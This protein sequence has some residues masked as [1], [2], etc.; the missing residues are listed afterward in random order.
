LQQAFANRVEVELIPGS[1]GVYRICADDKQIFSKKEVNRF[2][3]EGEVLRLL[4]EQ[5]LSA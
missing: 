1:G 2:P 3:D 4:H 5:G